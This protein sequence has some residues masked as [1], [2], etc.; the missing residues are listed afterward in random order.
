VIAI[1]KK[2]QTAGQTDSELPIRLGRAG[3][4]E[5]GAVDPRNTLLAT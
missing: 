3:S 4:G 2:G 5:A 1:V